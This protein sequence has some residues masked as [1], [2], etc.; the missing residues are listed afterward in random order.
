M[1]FQMLK[2]VFK[3]LSE[4]DCIHYQLQYTTQGLRHSLH[5]TFKFLAKYVFDEAPTFP[6]L[7]S[8]RKSQSD[9]THYPIPQLATK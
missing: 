1:S 6:N 8:S 7:I 2:P 9:H 5:R 3:L 4:G